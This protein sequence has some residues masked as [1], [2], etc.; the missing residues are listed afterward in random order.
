M[1]LSVHLHIIGY[2]QLI[3]KEVSRKIQVQDYQY[4]AHQSACQLS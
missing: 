1:L 4:V 2:R 3:L